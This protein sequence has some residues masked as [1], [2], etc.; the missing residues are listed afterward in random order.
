MGI[1]LPINPQS[2]QAWHARLS[3]RPSLHS[4]LVCLYGVW[5]V[6]S[7][8]SPT[9][10][11]GQLHVCDGERHIS[12]VKTQLSKPGHRRKAFCEKMR[13]RQLSDFS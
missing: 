8:S 2:A 4:T 7:K 13:L 3:S 11:D 5:R 12:G 10:T 1:Y 9:R 6:L